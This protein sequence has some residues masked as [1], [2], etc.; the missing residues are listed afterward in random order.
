MTAPGIRWSRECGRRFK[1]EYRAI[2]ERAQMARG[3]RQEFKRTD[4]GPTPERLAIGKNFYVV[5]DNKQGTR[6]YQFVDAPLE[7]LYS[8]LTKGANRRAE[9]DALRREY[10]ALQRYKHHWHAAGL[11]ASVSSVDLNRIFAVDFGQMSGM[12]KSERQAHHRQQYRD[13][14]DHVGHQPGIVLDNVVCYEHGLELAGYAIGYAS[15]YRA[16]MAATAIIR[17]AGTVLAKMWGVG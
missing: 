1:I 7:R 3:K 14:R 8:R 16:R 4:T 10:I 6:V 12:A 5:G 15:P 13:A 17:E 2:P 9:E 11:R